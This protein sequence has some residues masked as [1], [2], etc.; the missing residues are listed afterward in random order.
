MKYTE[1][2]FESLKEKNKIFKFDTVFTKLRMYESYENYSQAIKDKKIFMGFPTIDNSLGGLR[3][4]ELV[5]VIAGTNIGK[6]AFAMNIMYNVS[7]KSDGLII[8]FSLEMSEIDIFERYV[9]MEF[10]IF[11]Y[12]V[13]NIFMKNDKE[14]K[15]KI[16][17][18]IDR[19]KNIISVVK[20][21]SI[22]EIISYVKTIEEIQGKEC[23]LLLLDHVG[24]V[25]N[26]RFK[27][28]FQKTEDTMTKLKEISL[29]TKIPIILFSQTS[30]AD[31]KNNNGLDLYS[32]KNSGEVEN[33]S[34]IVFTLEK[35]KQIDMTKFDEM[36]VNLALGSS[37]HK[38]TIDILKLTTRKKKRGDYSEIDIIFN[39]KNLRMTEY[40]N[41]KSNIF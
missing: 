11:T 6:S 4:S 5:T 30:R 38:P 35:Q 15:L 16:L 22:N 24:L 20:R 9:Q 34:Q 19:H 2:K 41:Q 27:D 25:V 21:I 37:T 3:P 13:E 31:I 29:H 23:C 36:T 33:S 14:Y 8:L 26:D 40:Q 1:E 10:D 7:K 17:E 12:E 39:K 28:S 18:R 32:G